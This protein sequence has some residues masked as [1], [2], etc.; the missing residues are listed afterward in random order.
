MRKKIVAGNWKMNLS[1]QQ[2]EKLILEILAEQIALEKDQEIVLAVP[3]PYLM[4]AQSLTRGHSSTFIAAQNCYQEDS[5]AFTGEVSA[6]MLE[7]IG[8][9][10]VIIG[11]SERRQY[12]GETSL[13]LA[14]KIDL[15]LQHGIKPIF[16][17]GEPLEI[18][19]EQNQNDFVHRQIKE[20]LFHLDANQIHQT[21]L[22]YEP[23]WAIG[24]GLTA[25]AQQAQEMHAFI[26]TV[27][28]DQFG[29]ALAQNMTI[30]DGGSAKPD[31]AAE[32]F[33]CPDVDGGLI[34]GASLKAPD[35]IS[36]IRSLSKR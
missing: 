36:I 5:G 29:P 24:T 16:C 19:K 21:V 1:L 12:F 31:N 11:H 22:A 18:R 27:L 4:L 23:I 33:S 26:R 28:S 25:S 7:S 8:V 17:C 35:F 20:S 2:A 9:E 6:M 15:A 13:Q 10:Y 14:K 34:G 30:L 3:F 32:L